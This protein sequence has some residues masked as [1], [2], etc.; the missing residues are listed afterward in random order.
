MGKFRSKNH[1]VQIL[2][3][4][5]LLCKFETVIFELKHKII[6]IIL[7]SICTKSS[8]FLKE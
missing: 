7:A 3:I 4:T 1:M 5:G 6:L 8:V 2:R